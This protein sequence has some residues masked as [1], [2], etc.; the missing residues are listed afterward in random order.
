M[1]ASI[2]SPSGGGALEQCL[3]RGLEPELVE[4][5]GAQLGDQALE[6]ANRSDRAA[7]RRA[8]PCRSSASGRSG[9]GG[10]VEHELERAELLQRLVVQ[11]AR[12]ALA[13]LVGRPDRGAQPLGLDRLGRC[14]RD[15]GARARRRSGGALRRSRTR[16]SA[17]AVEARRARRGLGRGIRAARAAPPARRPPR[18]ASSPWPGRWA[19]SGTRCAWPLSNTAVGQRARQRDRRRP[20]PAPISPAAAATHSSADPLEQHQQRAA[21]RASRAR[22]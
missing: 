1:L 22:A 17:P 3:E 11:L 21:P 8:R 18:S 10:R 12:P 15:R 4:G 19:R 13:L 2:S 9:S 5:G 6:A 7:R 14:D 16:A 20:T